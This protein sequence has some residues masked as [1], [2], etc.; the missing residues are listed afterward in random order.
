MEKY[1]DLTYQY[2]YLPGSIY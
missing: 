1:N 2:W